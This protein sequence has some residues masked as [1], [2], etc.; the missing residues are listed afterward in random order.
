MPGVGQAARSAVRGKPPSPLV[1]RRPF[2][3]SLLRRERVFRL[4]GK[5]SLGDLLCSG[6]CWEAGG[7]PTC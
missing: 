6:I 1:A 3:G 7:M 2:P 4:F 5:G